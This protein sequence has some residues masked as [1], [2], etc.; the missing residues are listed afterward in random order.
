MFNVSEIIA[1]QV[2]DAQSNI[3]PA[4]IHKGSGKIVGSQADNQHILVAMD[5]GI[6]NVRKATCGLSRFT[7]DGATSYFVSLDPFGV[8]VGGNTQEQVDTRDGQISLSVL[9]DPPAVTTTCSCG[10]TCKITVPL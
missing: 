2:S 3:I 6:Y 8:D 5:A 10:T 9:P 7:C 1:T 4:N